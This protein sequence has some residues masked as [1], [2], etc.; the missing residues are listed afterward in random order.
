LFENENKRHL[1]DRLESLPTIMENPYQILKRFIKWEIMD[2]E[3]MIETIESKNEMTR[4][5]ES[6]LQSR[7]KDSKEL[8]KLQN[9][10]KM[11]MTKNAKVNRITVLNDR[12]ERLAKEIDCADVLT[13]IIF[14]YLQEAAIPFFRQDKLGVYNGAINLYAQK[15]INNC[16]KISDFYQAVI[17]MNQ[18]DYGSNGGLGNTTILEE[19]AF[20]RSR[21][22]GQF[23]PALSA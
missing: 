19:K 2:L 8:F 17:G 7:Q 23:D 11:F 4:R 10:N 15:Q 9:S 22:V 13:K 1:K 12:I 18:I 3:A 21:F 14:L 16:N 20:T 5:R 6:V